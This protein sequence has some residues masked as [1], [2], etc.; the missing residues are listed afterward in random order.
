MR[1]EGPQDKNKLLKQ[2]DIALSWPET[3]FRPFFYRDRIE[4]NRGGGI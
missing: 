1:Y 4:K 2:I 3:E